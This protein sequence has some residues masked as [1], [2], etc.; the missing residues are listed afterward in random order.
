MPLH[1]L[2]PNEQS[3]GF[4]ND[5]V[6]SKVSRNLIDSRL[7]AI[8]RHTVFQPADHIQRNVAAVGVIV[9]ETRGVP[10]VGRALHI[11]FGWKKQLK[12]RRQCADELRPRLSR[13]GAAQDRCIS[14]KTPLPI[15]VTQD[16][17]LWEGGTLAAGVPAAVPTP[18]DRRSP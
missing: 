17:D 14:A 5:K 2:Q 8:E 7:R 11:G 15:L 10:N 3:G 6:S 1:W 16:S 9:G 12:A 4:L 18:V 13:H